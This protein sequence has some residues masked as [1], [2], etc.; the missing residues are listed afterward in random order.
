MT[1][2]STTR[3]FGL[4]EHLVVELRVDLQ[5]HVGGAHAL[6]QVLGC[7]RRGSACP[8]R[9]APPAAARSTRRPA[10]AWSRRR[11]SAPGRYRRAA[12]RGAPAGRPCRRRPPRGRAIPRRSGS[13]STGRPGSD[14]AEHLGHEH[15]HRRHRVLGVDRRAGQH[16]RGVVVG[17]LD[18]VGEHDAA[19]HAVA[20]HDALAGRGGRRRRCRPGCGSRRCIRRCPAGRPAC[21]RSGRDRG[22]PARR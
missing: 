12:C 18:A 1:S 16:H 17:V 21:R 3:P 9:R 13:S 2:S 22:G 10:A 15:H 5:V 6:D 4:V 14:P 8:A 19:A 7:P 11:R 20:Q